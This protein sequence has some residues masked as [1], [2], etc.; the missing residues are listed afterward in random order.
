DSSISYLI[1]HYQVPANKL[2][3]G[4]AFY[5]R[6]AKT[7][8]TP[9]LFAPITG[10]DNITFSDDDGSP[11]YFN[12]LKKQNLFTTHWDANAQVPYLTGNGSLHTFVSY[13]DQQSIGLKAAYIKNKNLRG[14]IIWEITGDYIETS[15]GSSVVGSTPLIDTLKSVLCNPVASCPTPLSI[16]ANNITETNATLTWASSNA[17]S[18]VIDYK[19]Q[20]EN[21]WTTVTSPS[22][23]F[24]LANL[25]CNTTYNV[26]IKSM[27]NLTG[28]N[29]SAVYSFTTTVCTNPIVTITPSGT[30][31]LCSGSNQTLTASSGFNSYVWSNGD[32]TQSIVVSSAG[33][34]QVTATAANNNTVTSNVVN[35]VMTNCNTN[36]APSVSIVSPLNN[37]NATIGSTTQ[38]NVNA[39]DV[40]GTISS[41]ELYVNNSLL[42]S[43]STS[44]Y[45]FSIPNNTAGAVTIYAKAIDNLG[46][47]S[48]SSNISYTVVTNTSSTCGYALWNANTIYNANDMV[49]YNNV[50]YK[51][52]YW[53]QNNI[54]SNSYGN[55]CVWDLVMPCGGYNASTCFKPTFDPLIAYNTHQEVFWNGNTYRAK[56]WTLNEDPSSHS[57]SGDVWLLLTTPCFMQLDVKAFLQGYYN[58]ASTLRAVLLNSGTSINANLCDMVTVELH[59]VMSPSVVSYSFT[60]EMS[61]NGFVTCKFPSTLI[62]NSYYVV[63]KHR[64]AIETWSANPMMMLANT[65]YDFTTALN[66]AYGDNEIQMEPGVFAMFTGDLNQDGYI[67]S[68]DFPTLDSDIFNGVNSVYVNTD[69]NGDGFVDSFDFPI[70]DLNSY[71]GVSVMRP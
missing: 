15:P 42:G 20:N 6:S 45:N 27:C 33:S 31:S 71:N 61:I 21:T 66:K 10:V 50:I 5:G 64:N 69:L 16:V 3:A 54:P 40:D 24:S 63:V 59:E 67:D 1:N 35:I 2:A 13:D 47:S 14:A 25:V 11:T 34:Y 39:S 49:A 17:T 36:I 53:S 65:N 22:N 28:S 56:W 32:T 46:A 7:A 43:V 9:A 52:K 51:A 62:G 37:S 29:Y 55:C 41:V 18:Y 19:K 48:Q 38:V 12:I 8:G 70:F 44:P 58:G 30:I 57:G 26:R 4:V 68:F 60:G 23:S